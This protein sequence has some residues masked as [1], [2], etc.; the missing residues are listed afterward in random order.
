MHSPFA[1]WNWSR[2]HPKIRTCVVR[3]RDNR[4]SSGSKWSQ[5]WVSGMQVPSAQTKSSGAQLL[6]R[7]H[8]HGAF[9][10]GSQQGST[11][12]AR[13][14]ILITL[15]S[16]DTYTMHLLSTNATTMQLRK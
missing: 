6:G 12:R 1:H 5:W 7:T 14:K 9:K 8:I 11:E 10:G 13:D 4:E 2:V 16:G 15:I 3:Q